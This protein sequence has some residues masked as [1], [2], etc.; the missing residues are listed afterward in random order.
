[1]PDVGG[2]QDQA[3]RCRD[4]GADPVARDDRHLVCHAGHDTQRTH[5]P[6]RP[7]ARRGAGAWVSPVFDAFPQRRG[8]GGSARYL[9]QAGVIPAAVVVPPAAKPLGTWTV[10]SFTDDYATIATLSPPIA[11]Q[12]LTDGGP[13]LRTFLDGIMGGAVGAAVDAYTVGVIDGALTQ[14]QAYSTSV[15]GTIRAGITKLQTAYFTATHLFLNPAD[16]EGLAL[17]TSN[18]YPFGSPATWVPNVVV[19][20]AVAAGKGWLADAG[21]AGLSI[22]REDASVR[23]DPFTGFSKNQSTLL[24]EARVLFAPVALWRS[25]SSTSRRSRGGAGTALAP[26][27]GRGP[28]PPERRFGLRRSRRGVVI[29]GAAVEPDQ[30]LGCRLLSGEGE[31]PSL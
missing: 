15:L 9:T 26:A 8:S 31:A 16:A 13:D 7:A 12:V 30:D 23:V 22:I 3:G 25:S 27:C 10:S 1:M 4:L 24:V 6:G 28:R 11:N 20:P 5:R 17:L 29:R 2:V 21:R 14:Q 18:P 19:A